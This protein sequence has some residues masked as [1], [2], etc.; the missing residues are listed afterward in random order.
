MKNKEYKRH[1]YIL[2]MLVNNYWQKKIFDWKAIFVK[3]K[4]K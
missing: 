3:K 4:L 2:Q 1:R